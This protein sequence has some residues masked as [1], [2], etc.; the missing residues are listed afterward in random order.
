MSKHELLKLSYKNPIFLICTNTV[1]SC[2]NVLCKKNITIVNLWNTT[3]DFIFFKV[4][5]RI[6]NTGLVE[7]HSFLHFLKRCFVSCFISV[8]QILPTEKLLV[9]CYCK[10]VIVSIW[11]TCFTPFKNLNKPNYICS[12]FTW[13]NCTNTAWH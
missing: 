6:D 9:F 8:L 11:L 7:K 10:S 12:L 13:N 2:W 1:P 5:K 3:S 4:K